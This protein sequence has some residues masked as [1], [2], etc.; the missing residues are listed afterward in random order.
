MKANN[1]LRCALAL[2]LSFCSMGSWAEWGELLNQDF[3]S[4][5]LGVSTINGWTLNGGCSTV[6]N[7]SGNNNNYCLSIPANGYAE[8]PE[9]N[10][11]GNIT[12]T[13]DYWKTTSNYATLTISIEGNGS[14]TSDVVFTSTT[15]SPTACILES[16]N[17]SKNSKIRFSASNN[18]ISIDNV[19]I[20]GNI[21]NE[22]ETINAPVFSLEEGFYK[23][24]Q[25]LSITGSENATIFYT[26]DG[27]TPTNESTEYT[28]EITVDHDMVVKAIAYAGGTASNV[29][30]AHYFV[31]DYLFADAFTNETNKYRVVN[32]NNTYTISNQTIGKSAILSLDANGNNELTVNVVE[33]NKSIHSETI[34]PTAGSWN[35]YHFRLPM[36]KSSNNVYIYILSS[37]CNIDNVELK[38]P[39]TIT[40]SQNSY[41]NETTISE[42]LNQIVDVSTDR[43]LLAGVCHTMCLPFDIKRSDMNIALGESFSP[44]LYTFNNCSGTTMSF[45][46]IGD[47]TITAGTPFLL[48]VVKGFENLKFYA[49]KITATTPTNVSFGG[50]TFKGTFNPTDLATDGTNLF[51]GTDNYLYIP[52][53]ATKTLGGLRAYIYKPKGARL[54]ITFNDETAAIHE[55]TVPTADSPLYNLQGQR[56][57]QPRTKSLY[58]RNGKK[59][60]HH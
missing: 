59:M 42:N 32:T 5:G 29:T 15:K 10:T 22:S 19:V 4:L 41:S 49:V 52:A 55:T 46:E 11:T 50:V 35:R 23:T 8:T 3:N 24:G 28:G 26:I 13:F 44:L 45:T 48:K 30:T 18:S 2:F 39:A 33:D 1:Y 38:T 37:S 7:P 14:F 51:L 60:I 31:H 27:S 21:L 36:F 25:S 43:T 53:S 16:N 12:L 54:G 57:T 47:G 58:I 40:L 17:F 6:Y 56:I 34:I 9:I 20:S